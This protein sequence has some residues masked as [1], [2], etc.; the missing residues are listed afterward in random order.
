MRRI[1][2]KNLKNT[3]GTPR[4]ERE[5]IVYFRV[6]NSASNLCSCPI[7]NVLCTTLRCVYVMYTGRIQCEVLTT[8]P[9]L[10]S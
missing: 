10:S 2:S 7:L 9:I 1:S 8:L 3:Y 6:A 5:G 4:R